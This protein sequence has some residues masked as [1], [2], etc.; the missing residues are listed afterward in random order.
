MPLNGANSYYHQV[1]S[2]DGDAP[3]AFYFGIAVF[4]QWSARL[5]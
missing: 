4:K 1:I 2:G 5:L 3:E